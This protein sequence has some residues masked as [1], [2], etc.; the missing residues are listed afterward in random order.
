MVVG[1][2]GGERDPGHE[3][4]GLREIGEAKLAAD[5]LRLAS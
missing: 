3:G 4:E 2:L 5:R 1:L